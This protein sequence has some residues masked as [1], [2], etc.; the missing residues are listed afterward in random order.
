LSID[1]DVLQI[2]L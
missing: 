1:M 2:N